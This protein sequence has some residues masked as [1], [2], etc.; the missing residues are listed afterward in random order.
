MVREV[1]YGS[2]LHRIVIDKYGE[3]VTGSGG[4]ETPKKHLG[5]HQDDVLDPF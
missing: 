2:V 4:G 5:T 1:M 3:R